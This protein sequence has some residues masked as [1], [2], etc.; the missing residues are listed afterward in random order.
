M[1]SRVPDVELVATAGGGREA[2]DMVADTRP[3]L[4]LVD[5]EMPDVDGFDVVESVAKLVPG[6]PPL[7]AFVTAYR[8]FA[9]QAFESGAIDFLP[10][11]V[12][13]GRLEA[14]LARARDAVGGREAAR[15]L[16][17]LQAM[18]DDLRA[19]RGP[20]CGPHVWV[21]R[22]GEIMRVDLDHVQRVAAEGA[23]VRLHLE[24]GSYLHRE[25]IGAIEAK[26]DPLRFVRVHRSHLVRTDQVSSIRRTI[27]GGGEL[28][29]RDGACVPLGRKYARSARQRLLGS[30]SARDL[31]STG[32]GGSKGWRISS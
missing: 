8:K 6:E 27:H 16:I 11:P 26:L 4:L 25:P 17:E 9:P 32:T 20:V 5:I 18:L 23:Y 30:A 14:T 15:R 13:L 24:G 1:L 31:E 12:R 29:L 10:K 2:L 19:N 28:V 22:R 3:D 7:V 21:P